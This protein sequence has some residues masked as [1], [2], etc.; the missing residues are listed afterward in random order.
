M[1]PLCL[2]ILAVRYARPH[3]MPACSRPLGICWPSCAR[4]CAGPIFSLCHASFGASAIR[5]LIGSAGQ[6]SHRCR[7]EHQTFKHAVDSPAALGKVL[8]AIFGC[9]EL[10]SLQ[11][12]WSGLGSQPAQ[13]TASSQPHPANQGSRV[14]S[15]APK[16]TSAHLAELKKQFLVSYTSVLLTPSTMP[17]LRLIPLAAHQEA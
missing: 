6:G 1:H 3:N 11:A 14:E 16:I 2:T 10:T 9:S 17:S 4:L 7:L 5:G 8:P 13:P 15:F 12:A